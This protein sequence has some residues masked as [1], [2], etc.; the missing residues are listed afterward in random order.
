MSENKKPKQDIPTILSRIHRPKKAVV[1]AGM[2]Y[3]NGP[4]HIGHL[5][6]AHVPADVYARWMRLLIGKDNVLFVCG[7]DDHGT[8]S[9]VA[10]KKQGVTTDEFISGVHAK[11]FKTMN[12]F[13]I[14]LDAYSGTSKEENYETHKNICQDNLRDLFNNK[15]LE[16]RTSE[17]WFDPKLD[18]FLPDRFVQGEC[19]SCGKDGAYSDECDS[20]GSHYEPALL[21]NPIC[22]M[23]DGTPELRKTD[24]WYLDMWSA[25]DQM[26]EWLDGKKRTWRKNLLT[27][28]LGQV[29]PSVSID[30]TDEDKY[31][32]FKQELPKHKA[33]Y[34]PGKKVALQF[35][36]LADLSNAKKRLERDNIECKIENDW[37]YRSITRDVKWGIPVPE[38][39]DSSMKGKTLYVWPESLL[40]PIGFTQVAL[41]N[42]G[43]DAQSWKD[44]W[45]DPEAKIYQFLGIDNVFFYVIMQSAMWYGSQKDPMRQPILGELQMNEVFSSYHL[46]V[47]GDKMSKSKGNY[48]T[49]DQLLDEYGYSADQV[50]YFLS[51]LSLSEK[52]SNFDFEGLDKRNEFL[53]GP[54]NAAFEKP[55]SACHSKFGSVIPDGKLIGKTEKE[56]LKIVQT[57]SNF[58]QKAEY[59]KALFAV[60]NYARV[61]NSLFAQYKPHDDRFDDEQRSDALYSCFYILRNLLIMLSPFA[62]ETMERLRVSLNLPE[63]IYHIDELGKHFPRNHKIADQQE[64]FPSVSKD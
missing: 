17:Q 58:M 1:T 35:E 31:K 14:S 36:S 6:G 47:N 45:K 41:K 50:R 38:D 51:I 43:L 23:S 34:A 19:P 18:M 5:A 57:Y 55:I 24:H 40:A 54:L 12:R 28:V 63:D 7:T 27:E 3:A 10:A 26:L 60:E 39:I 53:A 8:N 61:I 25:T 9:E 42:K 49:A 11:Q 30:K 22:T 56:T 59:P 32:S 64:Y 15:R 46:Q 62:P 2:P 21:K 4:V 37:A 13:G 44:Y 20:C 29:M 52:A 48:Y 16:K 33:R